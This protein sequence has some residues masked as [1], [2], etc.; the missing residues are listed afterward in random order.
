MES[1]TR[2][3]DHAEH[4]HHDV[5][6]NSICSPR[7]RR[8]DERAVVATTNH[9]RPGPAREVEADTNF[10]PLTGSNRHRP[11]RPFFV[12]CLDI[13]CVY[14]PCGCSSVDELGRA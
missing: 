13:L 10:N 6:S 11:T 1:Y 9:H 12:A 4:V 14:C 7:S 8:R 3:P 5:L 2:L